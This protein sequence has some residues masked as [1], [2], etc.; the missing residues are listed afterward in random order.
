M[1][2]DVKICGLSTVG[3]LDIV[4]SRGASHVGFIH[5]P[6]SPRHLDLPAI[7]AL[8]E[9]ARGRAETVIVVVDPADETLD[10]IGAI[11]G[12]DIVQLHGRETPDRVAAVRARIGAK[13][14]KAISIGSA[15]DVAGVAAY[16]D[17]ADRLLLDAKRPKGSVLPGGNGVAFDWRLLEALDPS[18]RYMLSGGLDPGN[19]EAALGLVSPAGIDVSSGVESA[20][21]IKDVG[22]LHRFF[23]A[24]DRARSGAAPA[25]ETALLNRIGS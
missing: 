15:E 23:D 7:A 22:R 18:L 3:A 17:A 24:I 6:P 12:P 9:R 21:G 11:V 1:A 16:G 14:M 10:A 25:D 5:F 8:V 2:L 4:L 19:V 13:V 20:P